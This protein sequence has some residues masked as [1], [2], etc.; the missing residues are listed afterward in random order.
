M[1]KACIFID[2]ENFRHSIVELFQDR[3]I[4]ADY[5]PMASWD[6]LF[7]QVTID[8]SK[9]DCERL[10]AYWYV[11]QHVD[12]FPYKFDDPQTNTMGVK[13]LLSK[14]YPYEKELTSLSGDVLIARM[15]AI[16]EELE[17]RKVSFRKRSDGWVTVQNRIALEHHGIE[18]RRSGSIVYDLF[19]ESLN[20]EKAVDVKLA[21]DLITLNSIYDIAIIISGDQDYVPAVEY[22]KNQGKIV[23][24]VTFLTKNGKELP[25][26]ARRLNHI[27]D[28]CHQIK[29]NDLIKFMNFK[30]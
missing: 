24:N 12:Y 10:R 6:K 23:V 26:G 4:Q 18:F 1:K 9:Q 8:A 17:K 27:T 19:E 20:Q 7:D 30:P 21:T 29:Y 22:V 16:I 2:G 28:W 11:V 3:F 25:G 5:L 13:K 15:Q 14:H